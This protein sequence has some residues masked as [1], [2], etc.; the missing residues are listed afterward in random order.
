MKKAIYCVLSLMFMAIAITSCSDTET[1]AE[2]KEYEE[3]RISDFITKYKIKVISEEQFRAQDSTT[4]VSQNEYVLISSKGI[5]M[6]I[7][8]KGTGEKLKDG[9]N[10][11]IDVRFSEWNIN[12]DSLQLRNDSIFDYSAIPDIMT[13]RNTSGTFS[14]TF[15]QGRMASVYGSTQVP[16]GW[17]VP[18][19]Y[20]NLGRPDSP[21]A[22]DA[23]VKLILPHD[24][25]QS[26]ATQYVYACHYELT[27]R[28]GY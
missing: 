27:L 13:V 25:G 7:V 9:E 23:K 10:A 6:Q 8:D 1:Y 19:S 22:R 5:Y 12:G 17:L 24:Q 20:I 11:D 15:K 26:K 16:N 3:G 18:L 21:T 28:R 4:D 2:Q 14:A